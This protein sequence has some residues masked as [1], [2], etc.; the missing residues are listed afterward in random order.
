[1]A[2]EQR[3][4]ICKESKTPKPNWRGICTLCKIQDRACRQCNDCGR[5]RPL[6]VLETYWIGHPRD[7][8]R[9]YRCIQC[10]CAR[11]PAFGRLKVNALGHVQR[12]ENPNYI[13]FPEHPY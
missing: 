2:H 11:D 8:K 10:S 12:S 9:G 13:L 4:M 1:M 6:M 5:F 3:S 7:S